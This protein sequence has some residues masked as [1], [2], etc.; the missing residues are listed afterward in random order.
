MVE[1]FQI[2]GLEVLQKGGFFMYVILVE[3]VIGLYFFLERLV[4][5]YFFLK[6]CRIGMSRI[7]GVEDLDKVKHS[8][9]TIEALK[10]AV[11][12]GRVNS[13][14]IQ[15]IAE[16]DL[17]DAERGLTTLSV[18]AQSAPLF[19]LLG[20]ITGL[21]S[22]FSTI[23]SLGGQVTPSDLAGGIWEALLTTVFGL[24]VGIPTLIA[25]NYFVSRLTHYERDLFITVGRLVDDFR[26]KKFEIV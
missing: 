25:H 17:Q 14:L 23:E 15:L 7:K 1:A 13:R 19:G 21:V 4:Y 3:S 22:V 16:K 20:T 9:H 11:K 10:S 18:I 5:Y 2:G 8:N 12:E 6:R 26:K 24:V